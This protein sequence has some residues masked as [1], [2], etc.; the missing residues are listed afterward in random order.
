MGGEAANLKSRT[1]DDPS[2]ASAIVDFS[3]ARTARRGRKVA[4]T[5]KAA[6]L[7]HEKARLSYLMGIQI[8][9]ASGAE[10]EFPTSE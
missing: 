9:H 5:T 4:G 8:S 7:A 2:D 1:L 10:F 3:F 6:L